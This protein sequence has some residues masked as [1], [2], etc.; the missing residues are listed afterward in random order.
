MEGHLLA[1]PDVDRA[2]VVPVPDELL[3][4]RIYAFLVSR[5]DRPTLPELKRSLHE[6]GLAAFKLPDRVEFV[7]AFPLT[8]LG[9]VDKKTLA[10]AAADLSAAP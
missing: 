9:K 5:R 4:E 1:H 3:G 7:D 2:A 6:R 8:P 10:A